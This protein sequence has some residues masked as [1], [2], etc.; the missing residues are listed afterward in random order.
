M[1]KFIDKNVIVTGA[2]QGVGRETSLKFLE[3]GA[4]V[5]MADINNLKLEEIK[6]EVSK[7]AN[8]AYLMKVD[9]SEQEDI[10]LMI[11]EIINKWGSIDYL[12][13]NASVSLTKNMM[14]ITVDDWDKVL[15]INVKGT[16]F[17][18]IEA[19]KEMIKAENGGCIINM[20][21]IAGLNGRPLF[22]PYAASKAAVINFTKSAALEFAKYNIRVN[23]IAPG[24]IDTP[25]WDKISEDL[26]KIN[27]CS[28][29]IIIKNW[30][31]KIPLKRLAKPEDITNTILFLCSK[32]GE[33]IT[34]QTINVCG[35]L[36]IV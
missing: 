1:K 32:E 26:S 2:A 12:V 5:L 34:G 15:N 33:Y 31:E 7:Y 6:T 10:S 35:G 13:N 11:K 22:L 30:I 18:M 16:F 14:D 20:A 36:S 17:I 27:N 29:E 24:T 23:S 3:E 4:N 28:K 25:M 19:A 21:S 8:R 9:I